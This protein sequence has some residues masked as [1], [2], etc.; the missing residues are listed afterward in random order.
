MTI[1]SAPA[2]DPYIDRCLGIGGSDAKKILDTDW[3]LLWEE[4]TRRLP[5][6]D[7]SR[8]LNVQLGIHTESFNLRWFSDLTGIEAHQPDPYYVHPSHSF[9]YAHLDAVTST[10]EPIEAK[11]T[12]DRNDLNGLLEWYLPQLQH[13]LAVTGHERTWLTVIYGN[14]HHSHHE[15]MRNIDYI[16]NLM[17]LEAAFWWHVK[18][19]IRPEGNAKVEETKAIITS[20]AN[21]TVVDDMI[22][23]DMNGNNRWAECAA[24]LIAS[25]ESHKIYTDA[26]K[27]IRTLI[28]SN[29]R[30]AWGHGVSLKRT[31]G[32]RPGLRIKIG[33]NR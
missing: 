33:D 10:G 11:H 1:Y 17:E 12:N 14:S 18:N 13:Y 19:D 29:V 3:I 25:A 6:P 15:I 16:D 27:E 2:P 31:G 5:A 28:D 22:V 32:P 26:N 21:D 30:E 24:D 23:K 20:I 4:K 7:L 9:M 8:H